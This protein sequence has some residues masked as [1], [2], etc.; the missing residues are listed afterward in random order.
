LH[1]SKQIP[2]IVRQRKIESSR[3]D[4]W[5]LSLGLRSTFP[6]PTW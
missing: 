3:D 1:S 2:V 6:Q 4:L 5:P